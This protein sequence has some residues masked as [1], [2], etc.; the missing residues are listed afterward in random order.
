MLRSG[1]CC[2]DREAVTSSEVLNGS[3]QYATLLCRELCAQKRKPRQ[4]VTGFL[5]CGIELVKHGHKSVPGFAIVIT[6]DD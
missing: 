1:A 4:F 5:N 6:A 2:Q 3:T